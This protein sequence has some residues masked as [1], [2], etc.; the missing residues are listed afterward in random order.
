MSGQ[1]NCSNCLKYGHIFKN[2][3]MPI[4]SYGII[5][6]RINDAGELE[7]LM[8][9]RAH[10]FGFID[11]IKGNYSIS[12]LEHLQSIID[13]MSINEKDSLLTDTYEN[14]KNNLWKTTISV[15]KYTSDELLNKLKFEN[16]RDTFLLK[17]LIESSKTS[18]NEPEYEFPKGRRSGL[19]RE[20]EIAIREF[21][22]ETGYSKDMINIVNNIAPFEEFLIGSNYKFYK[23]KYYLAHMNNNINILDKYQTSE[24]SSIEWKTLDNCLESIRPNALEKKQVIKN[25]YKLLTELTIINL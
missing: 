25:V 8:I 18:W 13:E 10:S 17:E 6:F 14:L 19:E 3:R 1:L 15:E 11:F 16:I 22:E 7:F 12:N 2:C 5:C 24:V 23:Y 21:E 4:S 9:C 20:L